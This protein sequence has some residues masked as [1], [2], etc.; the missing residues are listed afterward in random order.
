[1]VLIEINERH[2]LD[3]FYKGP[4]KVK[5]I[6]EPNIIITDEND[7][8]TLIHKDKVKKFDTYFHYRFLT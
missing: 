7:K 8:E 3:P 2:K 6:V 4:Y 1:M 5:S